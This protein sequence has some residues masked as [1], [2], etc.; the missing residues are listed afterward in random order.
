MLDTNSVMV[1][2]WLDV[3]IWI[4]MLLFSSSI[5]LF[6]IAICWRK[7]SRSCSLNR[8]I[9]SRL[10]WLEWAWTSATSG[11]LDSK[12]HTGILHILKWEQQ[13]MHDFTLNMAN[14]STVRIDL[15]TR[16][17]GD[18]LFEPLNLTAQVWDDV[19]V[20]SNVVWHIYHVL[21]HLK[22]TDG[23]KKTQEICCAWKLYNESWI[24]F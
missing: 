6:L 20:L 13:R 1:R 18:L 22:H 4:S 5:R 9:S 10:C 23:K 15:A 7:A 21:L 11:R 3:A 8:S 2:R 17:F 12:S 14:V 24:I 19:G 16:L